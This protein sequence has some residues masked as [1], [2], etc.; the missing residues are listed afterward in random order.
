MLGVFL[1]FGTSTVFANTADV[2]IDKDW[3]FVFNEKLTQQFVP[4]IVEN[5]E[6]KRE[7]YKVMP[8]KQ[9]I[10]LLPHTLYEENTE[11]TVYFP[12]GVTNVHGETLNVQPF[13]FHTEPKRYTRAFESGYAFTWFFDER[14]PLEHFYLDGRKDG[15]LVAGATKTAKRHYHLPGK[16]GQTRNEVRRAHQRQKPMSFIIK[17]YT[18]YH[19]PDRHRIDTYLHNGKYIHYFYDVHNQNKV[20]LILW[21]DQKIEQM[22]RTYY[23]AATKTY[24]NDSEALILALINAERAQHRLQPLSTLSNLTSVARAHSQDMINRNYFD[25]NDPD[26]KSPFDRLEINDIPYL[27]AGEN[28]AAGSID[29]FYLHEGLMDSFGHRLNILDPDFDKVGIGLTFTRD[30]RPYVTELFIGNE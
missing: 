16:V 9:S 7:H 19:L 15:Q 11:Y 17:G 25:H 30:D 22:A 18:R 23:P 8:N 12:Q 2:P 3:T 10:Q 14:Q 26:G 24:R 28:I 29:A 1:F 21:T 6:G 13:S 5:N 27:A 4:I 20:R